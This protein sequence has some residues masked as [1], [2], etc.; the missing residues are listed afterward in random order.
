MTKS[1]SNTS[2][3]TTARDRM[4]R[5]DATLT[6]TA[7][8]HPHE[9]EENQLGCRCNTRCALGDS[10]THTSTGNGPLQRSHP[11]GSHTGR[12]SSGVSN[13]FDNAADLPDVLVVTHGAVPTS[14]LASWRSRIAMRCLSANLVREIATW[15]RDITR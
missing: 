15:G 2:D 13:A 4:A 7:T 3:G 10:R 14:V 12:L 6:T 9:R 8:W 5:T 11:R 1:E